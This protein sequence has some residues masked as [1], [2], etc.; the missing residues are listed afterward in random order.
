MTG[1]FFIVS[2][3]DGRGVIVEKLLDIV[4]D[5]LPTPLDIAAPIA[6]NVK[7]GEQE[8]LKVADDVPFVGLAF[9]IATDPFVGKLCFFRIYAGTLKSGSYVLKL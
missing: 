2:G 1:E 6:D 7:T 5:Y 3:G 4:V 8:V 9:K